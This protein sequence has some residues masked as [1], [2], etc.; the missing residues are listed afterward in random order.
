MAEIKQSYQE[1]FASNL[2]FLR[3]QKKLSQAE[4]ASMLNI[5]RNKIT[6]YESGN[7]EPN[8]SLIAELAKFFKISIDQ[9]LLSNI[10]ENINLDTRSNVEKIFINT[11]SLPG[12]K[13]FEEENKQ[14]QT[15]LEGF[16]SMSVKQKGS[17]TDSVE[18]EVLK[19]LR[20]LVNTNK[21]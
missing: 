13:Q 1:K 9:L 15:I 14:I 3:K 21:I 16:E 10:E 17:G 6:S 11:K 8:L 4:L 5:T 12:L 18:A 19:V 2:R 7:V 20:L